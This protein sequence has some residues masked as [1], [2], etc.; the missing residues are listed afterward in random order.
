MGLKNAE[1]FQ[2]FE[3]GLRIQIR[4]IVVELI[5]EY[6]SYLI[7]I[8]VEGH[9]L[10]WSS[11]GGDMSKLTADL[12]SPPTGGSMLVSKHPDTRMRDPFHGVG[13][14]QCVVPCASQAVAGSPC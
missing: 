8:A 4:V 2:D 7:G 13:C 9:S 12:G 3:N 5:E 14:L 10:V 1:K 11:S 6:S